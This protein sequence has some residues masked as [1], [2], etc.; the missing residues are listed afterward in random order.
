ME[1]WT[2][3][4]QTMF[5]ISKQ[6][7]VINAEARAV[8]DRLTRETPSEPIPVTGLSGSYQAVVLSLLHGLLGRQFLVVANDADSAARMRDD[9]DVCLGENSATLFTET[10]R[11]ILSPRKEPHITGVEALRNLV[12][13]SKAI[14]VCDPV[15]FSLKLPP[16]SRLETS[17][18]TVEIGGTFNLHTVTNQLVQQGFERKEFVGSVGDFAIRGGI[19]DIFP[20]VG[21]NPIRIELFGE[22]V[23]SIREFDPLSQRSIRELSA[24]VIIPNML[25]DRQSGESSLLDYLQPD[26]VVVLEEPE[27][28]R[29]AF[30]A[31]ILTDRAQHHIWRYLEEVL[32]MFRQIQIHHVGR[33]HGKSITFHSDPQPAINGSVKVLRQ[34]L[35]D[36]EARGYATM[37][38]AESQSELSRLKSLL[39][40][41]PGEVV[42]AHEGGVDGDIEARPARSRTQFSL[43]SLHSGFILHDEKFALF[44]EH[45]IFNRQ[46]RRWK[47][48]K[49]NARAFS[50]RE[51]HE[52]RKGD[53]V[54]H[55]DFGIGRFGGL[56]TI[57]VRN[58]THEVLKLFY[59]EG[60]A[61]YVNLNYL[62]K[63]KKYSSK[64]G[65]VPKL[66]RLGTADWE[67]LK[68]RAKSRIKDIAR[69]LIQLYARRK[70]TPGYAFQRDTAWQ[71]ELEASF[72]YEDTFDQAKATLDV[73]QDMES[74][75]PMDRLICGDVGFGKTEVAVRAAFKAVL[76]GKQVA[77]LV[78]TTILALQHYHTFHDRTA[79]YSTNVEVIS[80]LKSK[81]EQT[82]IV[83]QLKAGTIDIIIGTHRLLSKD[84]GFKDLG[85][86]IIDEEH[87]FGVS[88]KEK[89]RQLRANVDTLTL[90]AT[91]IPRTLHFSLLGARDLSIIAT[92]PRNRL[93]V[94]T[95]ITQYGD[96]LIREAVLRETQRGGQVYFVHDQV[97]KIDEI[98][99]RL[100]RILPGLGVR[101][102]HGQMHAHE[103]ENVMLDFLE[104]RFEILVCTKIIESGLDIPNVNTIIINRADK[105]GMAELYQLRGRVGRSNVQ[106]YA[107]LLTPPLSTLSREAIHRMQAVEE[108]TELGSGF[109]LSMRDLE[110]RGAGNLLGGEQ[111]GFIETMGFETYSRIL[112]EAVGELREQEFKELFEEKGMGVRKVS[113]TL[114]EVDFEAL[115]P[116][117][118]VGSD[119]ERLTLYR[120]LYGIDTIPQLEEITAEMVDR[121][122]PTP[123]EVK[124]LL[125][126][127][128]VRHTASKLGFAKV[129]ISGAQM[130]VEFPPET[131]TSFYESDE[132]QSMVQRISSKRD[133]GTTLQQA[134]GKLK[135]LA[136]LTEGQD[137][138]HRLKFALAL[139]GSL[140]EAKA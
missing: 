70:S 136:R 15:A 12:T 35:V 80:R 54:V 81:K 45:Q 121:F 39:E 110:I 124:S 46:R 99:A 92:P 135:L 66:S 34:T 17:T 137:P 108:F 16:P 61:L 116:P 1:G 86:L 122:G 51:I 77:M 33:P 84:I 93:P 37:I 127:I 48:Q 52:L 9:L 132:F 131:E 85:L 126:V 57:A 105:F 106:A 71:K 5:D 38:A 58:M 47:K 41:E 42:G 120:R 53:Y 72:M 91:P 95:E 13:S 133:G 7:Q 109:N 11:S 3:F 23:E 128:R 32:P 31:P 26:A 79:R 40:D 114:V 115:I 90:T 118:Y 62:G 27:V 8:M 50:A 82:A 68:S 104:K 69:D 30:E 64:E 117:A 75:N 83:S 24:A 2:V 123:A 21:E 36:L 59:E 97:Q 111:S 25:D 19:V 140:A 130:E 113:E 28:I 60:D 49:T 6:L 65:H 125:E 87:R 29:G 10:R 78:P 20:F 119:S 134:G 107:Y 103:L 88:A 100:Q 139:L 98:A 89:L 18:I 67:R 43:N 56:Q 55:D 22:T 96:D 14:V 44:T 138:H 76:D 101:A 112:E 129:S 73:K 63:V 74:P 4:F 94:I 102:A